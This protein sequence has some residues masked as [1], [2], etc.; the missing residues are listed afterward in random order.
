MKYDTSSRSMAGTALTEL[1][2][3]T[4]QLNGRLI[5]AGDK[6]SSSLGLTSALWQVLGA[7]DE[8]PLTVAQIARNMGLTRQ[9]VRRSVGILQ[10]KEFVTLSNNP[11]HQRAHLVTLTK[12]GRK[13]LEQ[14]TDKQIDWVNKLSEN[15]NDR[16]L[17]SALQTINQVL[18]NLQE[19]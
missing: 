14:V 7:I 10:E 3:A 9:S 16:K 18:D 11:N 1:I 4:F 5:A 2:L 19:N 17:L 6:L 12:K 13:V 15:M 8:M